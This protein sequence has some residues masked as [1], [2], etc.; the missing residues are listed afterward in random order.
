MS[1]RVGM[2]PY[3]RFVPNSELRTTAPRLP[4]RSTVHNVHHRLLLDVSNPILVFTWDHDAAKGRIRSLRPRCPAQAGT[5]CRQSSLPV[6]SQGLRFGNTTRSEIT[7]RCTR[8]Y[9]M[10]PVLHASNTHSFPY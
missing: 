5:H 4:Q 7:L 10:T 8:D 1:H 6:T 2:S 3:P 9:T